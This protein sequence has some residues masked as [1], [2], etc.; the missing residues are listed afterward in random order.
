MIVT[1]RQCLDTVA[2]EFAIGWR[3]LAGNS[4][5]RSVSR[6]RH[7][8]MWLALRS[9]RNVSEIGRVCG[10]RDA[11]TVRHGVG[12]VEERRAGDH[13]FRRLTDRLLAT[14]EAKTT[15]AA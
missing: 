12:Q 14:I 6:P 8:A 13:E 11:T 5:S 15:E 3:E 4:R 2:V 10:G 7:V 9:G 1:V